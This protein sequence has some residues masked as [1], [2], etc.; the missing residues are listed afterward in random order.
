MAE[1]SRPRVKPARA[2]FVLIAAGEAA[3]RWVSLAAPSTASAA[4]FA[5]DGAA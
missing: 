5:G 3:I 2:A 4:D 1:V